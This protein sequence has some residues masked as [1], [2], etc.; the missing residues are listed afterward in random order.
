MRNTEN[1]ADRLFDMVSSFIANNWSL[2]VGAV[3]ALGASKFLKAGLELLSTIVLIGV[4]IC[5]LTHTGVLPPLDELWQIVSNFI[6]ELFA[7]SRGQ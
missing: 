1:I 2:V 3:I 4:A 7:F 5:V 6:S